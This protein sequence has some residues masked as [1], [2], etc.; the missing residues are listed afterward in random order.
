MVEKSLVKLRQCIE[1]LSPVCFHVTLLVSYIYFLSKHISIAINSYNS[2][3]NDVLVAQ[4]L[5]GSVE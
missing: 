3:F 2:L 1:F 4:L 5:I